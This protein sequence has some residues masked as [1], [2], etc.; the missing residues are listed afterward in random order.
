VDISLPTALLDAGGW[1]VAA[2]IAIG[3]ITGL[4]RGDLETGKSAREARDRETKRADKAT[5]QLER[6]SELDEKRIVQIEKLT[7]Q[8]D[9]LVKLMGQIFQARGPS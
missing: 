1:V 2:V 6:N 3:V 4:I 7:E 8:V 9:L 5:E